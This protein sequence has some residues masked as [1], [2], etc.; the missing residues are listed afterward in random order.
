MSSCSF[1]FQLFPTCKSLRIHLKSHGKQSCP[2][3]SMKFQNFNF[4]KIHMKLFH[5]SIPS[6]KSCTDIVTLKN[7]VIPSHSLPMFLDLEESGPVPS[8]PCAEPQPIAQAP[9]SKF[10]ECYMCQKAFTRK[11]SNLSTHLRKVHGILPFSCPITSCK[12]KFG[13]SRDLKSHMRG[14]HGEVSRRMRYTESV[15]ERIC[16]WGDRVA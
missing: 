3:C 7:A 6:L 9:A 14:V 2:K 15:A 13:Y 1:C 11:S 4:V 16:G 10:I 12:Q 8:L 5:T